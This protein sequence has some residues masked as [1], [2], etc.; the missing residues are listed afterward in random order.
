[1]SALIP[2]LALD[3]TCGQVQAWV[4]RQLTYAGFRVAQTFDL[5][6]AR[7][8]HPDCPCPHHGT[9]NC[10][11]QMLVLL[12]YQKKGNPVTLVLHG[13]DG[14]TWLSLVNPTG[15]RANPHLEATIRR[16][17]TPRLPHA[18]PNTEAAYEARPTV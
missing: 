10:D 2:F 12:I 16:I 7:L 11:C 5:Q 4:N 15:Q 9:G 1:M 18:L 13:Q 17:L 8:A 14:R 6:V 3:Q